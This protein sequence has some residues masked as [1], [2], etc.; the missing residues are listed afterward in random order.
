MLYHL[1]EAQ[2]HNHRSNKPVEIPNGYSVIGEGD[3]VVPG[4]LVYFGDT[5]KENPWQEMAENNFGKPIRNNIGI[6][7][8]PS[9]EKTITFSPTELIEIKEIA[10]RAL[11]DADLSDSYLVEL[12][13]KLNKDMEENSK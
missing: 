9:K 12:R 10:R 8:A 6:Y 4:T 13:E 1:T 3:T 2:R 7:I 11:Q 5:N